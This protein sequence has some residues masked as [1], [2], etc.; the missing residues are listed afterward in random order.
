MGMSVLD[1]SVTNIAL[2]TIARDLASDPA[3]SVW[4]VTSYQIAIVMSLLPAAALGERY[5]YLRIYIG[6]L[7]V[8]VAMSL[9][10]AFATSLELLAIFRFA[11]GFGAAAMMGVNGALMRHVWPRSMLGRGVGYNAM[12][13]ACTAAAGPGLAGV[14]LAFAGWPWLFLVNVPAG[15][16]ALALSASFGPRT[17]PET[18][19]YDWWD[20]LLSAATLGTVFLALSDLSHGRWSW[21]AGVVGAIGLG[22]GMVVIKRLRAVER[23]IIPL[24]LFLL[25][26][27]RSAYGASIAAFAAQMSL[28]VAL[29]FV[30]EHGRGLSSAQVG[31]L[32]LPMP[33]GLGV[34]SPIAG[35]LAGRSWAGKLSA[36]GLLG[37]AV[38]LAVISLLLRTGG[39]VWPLAVC[40]AIGGVGFGLFQAPNNNVMLHAA[41]LDRAGAA[42]GMLAQCRLMGQTGGALIASISLSLWGPVS[43]AAIVVGMV[44]ALV[45][46]SF[47]FRR[48]QS[49]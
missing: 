14:I 30:L 6:G 49:S 36:A 40:M 41:P 24:D 29:P 27:L 8:F 17:A 7:L 11:Q 42:G 2:P 35:R 10:C 18:M 48:S 32:V 1:S 9:A 19:R 38:T 21:R 20:A 13:I 47:A 12:I 31:L 3:K 39:P 44:R 28:L 37:F 16:V 22:I 26:P 5:G 34:V 23:P 33:I 15:M 45:S 43:I 4:V 46:A 25:R